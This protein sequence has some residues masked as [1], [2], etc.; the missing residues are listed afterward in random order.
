MAH[1]ATWILEKR[2]EAERRGLRLHEPQPAPLLGGGWFL[3]SAEEEMEAGSMLEDAYHHFSMP[4]GYDASD[5]SLEVWDEEPVYRSAG[6]AFDE[7]LQPRA[8]DQDGQDGQITGTDGLELGMSAAEAEWLRHEP[9]LARR[10][11]A[12]G[13]GSF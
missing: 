8:W 12:F 5:L 4:S 2:L 3:E 6:L 10:Q 1:H 9:P 7:E 11:R 13:G